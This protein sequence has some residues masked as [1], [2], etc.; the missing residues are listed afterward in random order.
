MIVH[1]FFF[2]LIND[3]RDEGA[4]NF[5]IYFLGEKKT[6]IEMF[7]EK[8]DKSSTLFDIYLVNALVSH[9]CQ[10]NPK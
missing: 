2:L 6:Q 5:V 9:H 8:P 10:L 7:V 3:T 4:D 1:Y